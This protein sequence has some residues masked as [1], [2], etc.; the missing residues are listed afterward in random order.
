[1]PVVQMWS[2]NDKKSPLDTFS[3]GISSHAPSPMSG[4]IGLSYDDLVL[5][6]HTTVKLRGHAHPIFA[7]VSLYLHTLM[8]YIQ[9][10]N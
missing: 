6:L 1:M 8:H 4:L 3:L 7:L 5:G 2:M 10:V 9:S